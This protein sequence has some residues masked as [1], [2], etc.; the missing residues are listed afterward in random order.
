MRD[1]ML[2]REL[3]QPGRKLFSGKCLQIGLDGGPQVAVVFDD[4][5]PIAVNDERA[6]R[7]AA[8]RNPHGR[9]AQQQLGPLVPL[10]RAVL[11]ANALPLAIDPPPLA[12]DELLRFTPR[13]AAWHSDA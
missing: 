11:Y 3:R 1:A 8:G 9:A 4:D 10:S 2:D 5:P 12:I 6:A 13:S 7:H